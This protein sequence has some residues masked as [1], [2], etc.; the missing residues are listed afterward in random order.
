MLL[1]GC[2]NFFPKVFRFEELSLI[3]RGERK[4]QMFQKKVRI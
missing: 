3:P 2:Y 4:L 1:Y